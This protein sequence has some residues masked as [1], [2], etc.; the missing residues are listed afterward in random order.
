MVKVGLSCTV[1]LR[2][3]VC[4]S[5]YLF[6]NKRL[7]DITVWESHASARMGRLDWSDTTV[8]QKT[9]VKQRLRCVS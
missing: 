7:D 5:V 1:T 8:S 6:G 4:T 3:V 9:D 2:V